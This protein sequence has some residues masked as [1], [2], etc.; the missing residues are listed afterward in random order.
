M[1]ILN[2]SEKIFLLGTRSKYRGN[3]RITDDGLFEADLDGRFCF[4][5]VRR[6]FAAA[7]AT[8]SV[9]CLDG[10]ISNRFDAL[11]KPLPFS[12]YSTSW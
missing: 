11:T 12:V 1:E 5:S 4:P 7:S 6:S 8:S 3:E 2:R 10:C 9:T